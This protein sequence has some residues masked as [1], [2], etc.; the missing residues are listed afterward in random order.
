MYILPT[1]TPQWFEQIYFFY[2]NLRILFVQLRRF[3]LY[4]STTS[5]NSDHL[6]YLLA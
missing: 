1:A 6:S 4:L 2:G 5:E 3:I